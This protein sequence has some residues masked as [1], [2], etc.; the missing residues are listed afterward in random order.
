[1]PSRSWILNRLAYAILDR[2]RS[3]AARP[4]PPDRHVGE[5]LL[6]PAGREDVTAVHRLYQAN[7]EGGPQQANFER[8]IHRFPQL[9][10]IA[11]RDGECLGYAAGRVHRGFLTK[12][13]SA[14]L[15]SIA[16]TETA[17]GLG[18]GRALVE[19]FWDSAKS[20]GLAEIDLEAEQGNDV[21][22]RLYT[23]LGLEPLRV[24][25]TADEHT[26]YMAARL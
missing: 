22:L 2:L 18:M 11:S 26:V 17:R 9:C 8:L 16:V 20:L 6:R 10:W 7:L 12:R 25:R 1:M 15:F 21:A 23:S 13:P 5:V 19:A 3:T 24:P 14:F 4:R